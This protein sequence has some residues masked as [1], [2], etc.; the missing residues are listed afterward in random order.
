MCEV[1]GPHH[2]TYVSLPPNVCLT[3]LL[4]TGC[5]GHAALLPCLRCQPSSSYSPVVQLALPIAQGRASGGDDGVAADVSNRQGVG[6]TLLAR[7]IPALL[8]VP[9]ADCLCWAMLHWLRP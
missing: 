8:R 9:C 4:C 7:P 6:G 3:W 1:G 5:T 2:P